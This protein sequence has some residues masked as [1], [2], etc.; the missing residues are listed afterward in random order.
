MIMNHLDKLV[1]ELSTVYNDGDM[2]AKVYQNM[3][4]E[5][6]YNYTPSKGWYVDYGKINGK[7]VKKVLTSKNDLLIKMQ[8]FFNNNVSSIIQNRVI[9]E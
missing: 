4:N 2:V 6:V 8:Q 1:V 3:E 5:I 9:F 7:I